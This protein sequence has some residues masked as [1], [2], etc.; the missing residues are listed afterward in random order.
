MKLLGKIS[1][2]F[3]APRHTFLTGSPALLLRML[4]AIVLFALLGQA[5]V[6]LDA[7]N[8]IVLAT[9]YRLLLILTPLTLLLFG[10]FALRVTVFAAL[11]G[12]ILLAVPALPGVQVVAVLLFGYGIAVLGYI[13]KKD[14]AATPAGAANNKIML[15]VGSLCA[16]VVLLYPHWQPL[17]F[18]LLLGLL[19]LLCL[20][21]AWRF[22]PS[23]ALLP[24]TA[25]TVPSGRNT[26]WVLAGLM[27]GIKLFAVF[28][29]LPQAILAHHSTL[30]AWYGVM[31]ILNSAV[32]ALLQLPVMKL[33]AYSGNKALWVSLLIILGGLVLLAMPDIF[34][35][36]TFTGALL[37]LTLLSIAECGLSYLDYCAAQDNALLIKEISVSAGA[38]LTVCVMRYLPAPYNAEILSAIAIFAL[39]SWLWLYQRRHKEHSDALHNL[40][41]K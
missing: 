40:Y 4:S 10:P 24:A 8:N 7:T 25:L 28:S 21:A 36:H 31:I 11:A 26:L 39:F 34:R 27:N 6:W 18:Y 1:F 32:V 2:N 12:V 23:A 33:I 17:Y 16:G 15:N 35:V 37:W 22:T 13:V 19:L 38:G 41:E 29:V 9:G 14:A 3:S 5:N 30:P 20:P